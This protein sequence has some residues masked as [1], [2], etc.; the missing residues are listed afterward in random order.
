MNNKELTSNKRETSTKCND[1]G[2]TDQN[3]ARKSQSNIDKENLCAPGQ[4]PD[5]KADQHLISTTEASF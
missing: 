3:Y 5:K 2:K 4:S 1:D